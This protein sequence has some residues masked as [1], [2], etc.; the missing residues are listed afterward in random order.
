MPTPTYSTDPNVTEKIAHVVLP[1]KIVV[2]NY[3]EQAYNYINMR[4]KGLYVVPVSGSLQ[5][6]TYLKHV[7]SEYSAGKVLLAVGVVNESASI[8]EYGKMLVKAAERALDLVAGSVDGK[9][10]PSL[11]FSGAALDPDKSD[12]SADFP[13]M[14]LHSPD[15]HATFDRPMSGIENDAI[16]GKVDSEEHSPLNDTLVP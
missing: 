13:A 7:E 10:A 5:D 12:N 16:L 11:T 2:G 8:S 14:G 15:E 9:S 6:M 1:E 4:L 3:R